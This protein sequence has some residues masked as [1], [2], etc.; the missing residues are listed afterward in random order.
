M[1]ILGVSLRVNQR[2]ANILSAGT[3]PIPDVIEK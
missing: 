3:K 2:E 1:L